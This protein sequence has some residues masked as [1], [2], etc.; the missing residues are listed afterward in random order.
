MASGSLEGEPQSVQIAVNSGH[1]AANWRGTVRRSTREVHGWRGC[2]GGRS[3]LES[4]SGHRGRSVNPEHLER[5]G[6]YIVRVPIVP[7][8]NLIRAWLRP[9]VRVSDVGEAVRITGFATTP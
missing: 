2:S 6:R 9:I 7:S 8:Q 5:L 1:F 4:G 3:S